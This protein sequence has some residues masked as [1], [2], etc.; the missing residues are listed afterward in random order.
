MLN[1][2]NPLVSLSWRANTDISPCTDLWAAVEYLGKYC[3][4]AEV[5]SFSFEETLKALIPIVSSTN[6]PIIQLAAK[7]MNKIVGG[8]DWGAQEV[9]HLLLGLYLQKGTR[10]VLSVDC[11]LPSDQ[12]R[13]LVL[14]DDEEAPP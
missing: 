8:R 1:H 6:Q 4:K 3:T 12:G 5:A 9:C 13:N 7:A 11:R 2:Y 14:N 10:V